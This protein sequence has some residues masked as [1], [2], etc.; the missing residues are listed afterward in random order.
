MTTPHRLI[1]GSS[2]HDIAAKV[3]TYTKSLAPEKQTI[4]TINIDFAMGISW[5]GTDD[6]L[7]FEFMKAAAKPVVFDQFDRVLDDYKKTHRNKKEIHPSNIILHNIAARMNREQDAVIILT[8]HQDQ[9]DA[10]FN[11]NKPEV[12]KQIKDKIIIE[13]APVAAPK[14]T[15]FDAVR[16]MFK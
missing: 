13:G 6:F 15:L 10:L 7:R 11:A 12:W 16:R 2:A 3:E 8:A 5:H 9:Y 4:H 1:L 14:Q